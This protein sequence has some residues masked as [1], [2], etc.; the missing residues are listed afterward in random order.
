MDD[1]NLT[2]GKHL[3]KNQKQILA[4]IRAAMAQAGLEFADE[5]DGSGRGSA[6]GSRDGTPVVQLAYAFGTNG[7]EV[8]IVDVVTGREVAAPGLYTDTSLIMDALRD[9]LGVEAE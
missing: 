1:S 9:V 3:R 7:I 5:P 6:K 2:P 8:T 4:M